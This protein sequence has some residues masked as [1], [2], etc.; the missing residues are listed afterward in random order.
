MLTEPQ[1]RHAV[2]ANP[3]HARTL[4]WDKWIAEIG[5]F[6]GELSAGAGEARL[7]RKIERFQFGHPPLVKDGVIG[8]RTWLVLKKAIEDKPPRMPSPNAPPPRDSKPTPDRVKALSDWLVAITEGHPRS[9]NPWTYYEEVDQYL[10]PFGDTGYPIA[11]GKKYCVLFNGNDTLSRDPRAKAWVHRTTVLLQTYLSEYIVERYQKGTLGSIT[12]KE[13]RDAAFA[14]HP[15]AYTRGGLTLLIMQ[16]PGLMSTISSIPAVEFTN[17]NADSSMA[18]YVETRNLVIKELIGTLAAGMAGP[19]HTGA[20][21]RAAEKDRLEFQRRLQLSQYLTD[22]KKGIDSG[23]IDRIAWLDRVTRQL[24]GIEFPDAALKK[25][26][27]D[28]VT[29]ADA[30]KKALAA[31]YRQEIN[32]VPALQPQFDAY[33]PGWSRW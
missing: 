9:T 28:I 16:S 30:R 20:L 31:S 24:D 18:Q 3:G 15:R 27:G 2:R 17:E 19:A 14:S 1:L 11:Y 6:F 7:A 33:D 10:G 23:R 8:P 21:T 5:G 22:L 12:E 13:L 32:L 29:A 26:A 4:G 25:L